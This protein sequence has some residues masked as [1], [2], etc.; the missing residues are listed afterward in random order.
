MATAVR[1]VEKPKL[2]LRVSF[3]FSSTGRY[4]SSQCL[5]LPAIITESQHG[6]GWKGPLWVTQSNP[7]SR[8]TQ[9]RLHSTAARRGLNISREQ[10]S[11]TSLG[12][13]LQCSI[14]LRGKK[15]FLIFSWSFLGFIL[16]PLPLVLSL[17][18]TGKSLAL[19]S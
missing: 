1:T 16:C 8:V 2:V 13:L 12:S 18:T 17:G 11:T 15:F 19:S 5:S 10:D 14:T 7:R 9:S 3:L 6:G 4:T